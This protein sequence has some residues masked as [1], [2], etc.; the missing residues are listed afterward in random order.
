MNRDH[1]FKMSIKKAWH[2]VKENIGILI[3]AYILQWAIPIVLV[4]SLAFVYV[5]LHKLLVGALVIH[6][7]VSVVAALGAIV[8]FFGS[9]IALS[10]GVSAIAL[11]ISRNEKPCISDLFSQ[12]HNVIPVC[13]G[14]ALYWFV[15]SIGIMALLIPGIYMALRWYF[16][17]YVLID[18]NVSWRQALAESSRITKGIKFRLFV[19]VIVISWLLIIPLLNFLVHIM[20]IV[21]CA[22]LYR[23]ADLSAR[24]DQA[25]ADNQVTLEDPQHKDVA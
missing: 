9:M 8:L 10:L 3:S 13:V 17:T 12:T 2:S 5:V 23:M 22:Y 19:Y 21:V 4:I 15:V 6:D 20:H 1:L 18:K 16:F 11:K 24:P 14:Y 7:T 25:E